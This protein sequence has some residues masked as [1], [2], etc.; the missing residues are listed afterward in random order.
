MSEAMVTTTNVITALAPS[1]S[2]SSSATND[3][4]NGM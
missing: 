4:R 2:A 1:S 3:P